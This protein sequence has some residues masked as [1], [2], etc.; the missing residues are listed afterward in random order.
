LEL[1][2]FY[3]LFHFI[4]NQGTRTGEKF[5]GRAVGIQKALQRETLGAVSR[6]LLLLLRRR[7]QPLRLVLVHPHPSHPIVVVGG[8]LEDLA[9]SQTTPVTYRR[10]GGASGRR[11]GGRK[12]WH[13]EFGLLVCWFVG[14]LVCWFVGW[15][16]GWLVSQARDPEISQ[17]RDPEI[18]DLR[19]L[20][21]RSRSRNQTQ[22]T[23]KPL[24]KIYSLCHT[25]AGMSDSNGHCNACGTVH[26][27]MIA[28]HLS[29][30]PPLN[31]LRFG[32]YNI[33][34]AYRDALYQYAPYYCT[35]EVVGSFL[36]HNPSFSSYDDWA[37]AQRE[38]ESE[39]SESESEDSESES[40]DS[41]E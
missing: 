11:R 3:L 41:E 40:E 37:N 15:L 9:L 5:L 7:R 12:D 30:V 8:G 26:D 18:S 22:Q 19:K 24:G 31:V 2:I 6:H 23:N 17:A 34:R 33:P 27:W 10:R 20:S 28:E 16:V 13:S 21:G 39:D 1:D 38:S 36:G 35:E 32:T 29:C 25:E 14:L 4:T